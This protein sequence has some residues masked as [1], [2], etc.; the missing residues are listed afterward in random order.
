MHS[1]VYCTVLGTWSVIRLEGK[2]WLIDAN[3]AA[4]Q[5]VMVIS[6]LVL[7]PR[8]NS[9]DQLTA[10]TLIIIGHTL[11]NSMQCNDDV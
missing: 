1:V 8:D 11:M 7:V 6:L 3:V 2:S 4:K 5:P 10:H 9:D